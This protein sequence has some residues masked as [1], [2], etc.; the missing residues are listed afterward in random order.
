MEL[1]FK[2]TSRRWN[3]LRDGRPTCFHIKGC[4]DTG[5]TC[6][7]HDKHPFAKVPTLERAKELIAEELTGEIKDAKKA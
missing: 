2:Y 4:R 1:T 3:V 5:Y 7:I 6:V